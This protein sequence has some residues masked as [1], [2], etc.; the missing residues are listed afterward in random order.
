M[1]A[2]AVEPVDREARNKRQAARIPPVCK[3]LPTAIEQRAKIL[4][5]V[6][7]AGVTSFPFQGTTVGVQRTVERRYHPPRLR[8]CKRN[9]RGQGWLSAAPR[10]LRGR[11]RNAG[12]E[13]LHTR[14]RCRCRCRCRRRRPRL[15]YD[16]RC[17]IGVTAMLFGNAMP[18]ANGRT[19][20]SWVTNAM[21]PGAN[22]S[23]VLLCIL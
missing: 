7:T 22:F 3:I 14:R 18:S 6:V 20:L 8:A 2:I 13:R 11:V 12:R 9:R 1:T 19:A 16:Q 17:V 21:I 4:R 23:P 10:L 5:F 15:G